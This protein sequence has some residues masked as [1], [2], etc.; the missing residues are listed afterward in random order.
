M[1]L[2]SRSID[3]DV[4]RGHVYKLAL[5][6][7]AEDFDCVLGTWDNLE[8]MTRK[9]YPEVAEKVCA[10]LPEIRALTFDEICELADY[11]MFEAHRSRKM[12]GRPMNDFDGSVVGVRQWLWDHVGLND[13]Y[14]GTGYTK[15]CAGT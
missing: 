15:G 13:D 7:A 4:D 6:S 12:W 5:F 14:T 8:Y 2:S 3:R 11:D 10:R 9:Y 1:G